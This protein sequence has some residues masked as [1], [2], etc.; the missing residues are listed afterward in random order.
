MMLATGRCRASIAC[1][2][3]FF[4]GHTSRTTNEIWQSIGTLISA[5]TTSGTIL[6]DRLELHTHIEALVEAA[7][8]A[9]FPRG[10]GDRTTCA[11][12]A[13]IVLTILDGALEK[14]LARFT[15]EDAIMEAAYLVTANRAGTV[16]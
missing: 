1:R 3:Q 5:S 4:T 12:K 14:S 8:W 7:G 15:R 9:L 2:R 13:H 10:H 16:N 6:P 11:S